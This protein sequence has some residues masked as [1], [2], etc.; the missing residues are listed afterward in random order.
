MNEG[1]ASSP[2]T[3]AGGLV[4]QP[5]S[6]LTQVLESDVDRCNCEGDVV[7]ALTPALEEAPDRGVA[8]EGLQQLDEGASHRDHCLLDTLRL[9]HLPVQGLH[10]IAAAIVVE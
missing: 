8:A 9:H 5:G 3:G 6:L 4:D 7:Q 10:P 2:A 1:D